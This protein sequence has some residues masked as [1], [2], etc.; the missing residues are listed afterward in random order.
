M[1]KYIAKLIE[2]PFHI[3]E[4]T[5]EEFKEFIDQKQWFQLDVETNVAHEPQYR[6]L[7]SVQFGEWDPSRD[8]DNKD[9]WFLEW[10]RL[11]PEQ[12]KYVLSIVDDPK[13][14]KVGQNLGFENS[15][16]RNFGIWMNNI[17]DT[18]LR[19]KILYTGMSKTL[20]EDGATFF[21]LES[22]TRRRLGMELSKEYQTM[23]GFEYGLTVGHIVYGCQDV[24]NLDVIYAQ[25]EE[26]LDKYYPMPIEE[27]TAY[28]YLPMLEDEA[29]LAFSDMV[30]NGMTLDKTAWMKL[31][32]EAEPIIEQYREDLK[33][34]VLEDEELK[35]KAIAELFY[36]REDTV[37]I[38][39]KSPVHKSKLYMH[40]F[41]DLA[42]PTKANLKGWLKTAIAEGRANTQQFSVIAGLHDGDY[43]PFTKLMVEHCR[44]FLIEN[45]YLIP[46]GSLTINW[47]SSDQVV[48]LLSAISKVDSAGREVLE[49]LEHPI[50][51]AIILFRQVLKLKSSFG[52]KFLD[53][54][55]DDGKVR[56]RINQILE[57]GRISSSSPNMQQIPAYEAVG[58]KYRNCFV[59][60]EGEVYVDSD[61]SSQELV[62]IAEI[63]Q[64]PVWLEAL[65]KGHDLHS[66]TAH[67]VYKKKW[68]DATEEG[69][70]YVAN[71]QKC[72]CKGHKRLRNGIKAINFGL[73][74]GMSHFKLAADM[75]ISVKEAEALIKEYFSTFPM[76][77]AKLTQLG[78]FAIDHGFISTLH[79]FRRKRFYPLWQSVRK[80]AQSHK[81]GVRYNPIL[82]SIE[83]TGKNTPIQ[84]TAA[85]MVKVAMVKTRR[86]ILAKKLQDD[87][88]LRMQV[89][90]QITTSCKV[91]YQEKWPK[92][93]TQLMEDSAK[94]ILP[95]GLL[96]AETQVS[97]FWTK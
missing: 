91:K 33:K 82:G 46:A 52:E 5:F 14:T 84:G 15:V 93:M 61:Y 65:R 72:K 83:R 55:D 25:Q 4:G 27:R 57:T 69:C 79:P 34:I 28:N 36:H 76:I 31:E 71:K 68:D 40:A 75:K 59:A 45:E 12:Q 50:G 78:W 41:P 90:D 73:A 77:G 21:S 23:F 88:K 16:F 24:S 67:L 62:I 19:E 94:V 17:K 39:F 35:A 7:R 54:V 20:D 48:S 18:M 42:G 29:S 92:I 86:F 49:N 11:T 70:D 10:E 3:V 66:V 13:R 2:D 1:I 64:D 43:E 51:Y 30:H 9:Q 44:D 89:H 63:A 22:I 47:G 74:Y 8:E 95:S 32:S 96:K 85:D 56:T 87:I 26:E 53:H 6:R 81:M 37:V 97:P 60:D 38:N 80:H 58:T